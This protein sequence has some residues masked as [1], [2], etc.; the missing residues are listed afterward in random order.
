MKATTGDSLLLS[1]STKQANIL[2]PTIK[3]LRKSAKVR[4]KKQRRGFST[5]K[6]TRSMSHFSK[7]DYYY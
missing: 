3:K 7:P 2:F 6:R 5:Q 4:R 1:I